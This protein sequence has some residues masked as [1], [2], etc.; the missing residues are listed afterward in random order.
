MDI[1]TLH[2][3]NP[4][5]SFLKTPTRV[6]LTT[7]R[8]SLSAVHLYLQE[9]S[10]MPHIKG[11]SQEAVR[12]RMIELDDG[13]PQVYAVHLRSTLL[14]ALQHLRTPLTYFSYVPAKTRAT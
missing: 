10:E 5:S 8:P 9:S 6:R 13:A 12:R 3:F 11:K 14:T 4:Y 7:S 2:P 1:L